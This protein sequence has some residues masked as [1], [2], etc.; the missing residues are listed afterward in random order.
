MP[1]ARALPI[2]VAPVPGEALDSWLDALSA[3]L[4]ATFGELAVS[5]GFLDGTAT[6][7]QQRQRILRRL[8][9]IEAERVASATG[10]DEATLAGMTLSR[11]EGAYPRATD[12]GTR[13]GPWRVFPGSRYCPACLA[14]TGGR[15]QLHWKLPWSFACLAHRCLLADVCPFC[16]CRPCAHG[17]RMGMVATP[18]HCQEPHPEPARRWAAGGAALCHGQLGVPFSP[19]PVATEAA[20]LAQERVLELMGTQR[21]TVS[22][23][24]PVT[25][26]GLLGDLTVVAHAVT[27]LAPANKC[28]QVY[29]VGAAET[30]RAV[31]VGLDVL[32]ATSVQGAADRLG[33]LLPGRSQRSGAVRAALPELWRGASEQLQQAVLK[34]RDRHLRPADRLR[35]TTAGPGSRLGRP[36]PLSV[37][38][39]RQRVVPQQFW[40]RWSLRLLPPAGL[41]ATRSG[42]ALAACLLLPGNPSSLQWAAQ[43]LGSASNGPRISHTLRHLEATG[44]APAVLSVLAALA[45]RLDT[46]GSPI[47]YQRRRELF[48]TPCFD[49][50]SQANWQQLCDQV[51]IRVGARNYRHAQRYLIEDLTGQSPVSFL[52]PLRLETADVAASYHTFCATMRAGLASLLRDHAAELLEKHGIVEPIC[53]EPPFHW[54][55]A[56]VRW[57]GPELHD[58]DADALS[59]LLINQRLKLSEA[60]ARLGTSLDH[61]RLFLRREPL[62]VEYPRH[63]EPTSTRPDKIPRAGP[64][65]ATQLR[66]HYEQCGW[67]WQR[68]AIDAGCSQRTAHRLGLKAGITSHIPGRRRKIDIDR[69]WL[70]AQYVERKRTLAD[71]ARELRMS[72]ASIAR[73]ARELGIELR[74]R[75]GASHATALRAAIED[76]VLPAS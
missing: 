40:P 51:G 44:H 33:L 7:Y 9:P 16:R 75:G 54:V 56:H 21:P 25:S 2:R 14:G 50:L 22:L 30:A 20:L 49:V 62:Q 68:I 1:R 71:I 37:L 74:K 23:G 72:T 41:D 53:W 26:R 19:P 43:R 60:A 28:R 10:V 6:V 63:R 11:F 38:E 39:R 17:T 65:S 64:L 15:W 66:Y 48:G 24:A 69:A 35:F 5:L 13:L 46:Y 61:V 58:L 73:I 42:P 32:A 29:R 4:G 70:E 18:A 12:P 67:S 31:V 34:S 57:P 36:V 8:G 45:D 3:R 52:P 59:D 55:P 47:D 76:Q 27:G